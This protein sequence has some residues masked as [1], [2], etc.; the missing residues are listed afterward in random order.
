MNTK[1]K[2]N[3]KGFSLVELIVVMA[4]MAILA[5]TLTP[6][7]TQYIDKARQSNDREIPN[8]VYTAVRLGLLDTTIVGDLDTAWSESAGVEIIAKYYDYDTDKQVCTLK[9]ASS[10]PALPELD[11]LANEVIQVLGK[12]FKFQSNLA[13]GNAPTI[14]VKITNATEG[15]FSVD[16]SYVDGAGKYTMDSKAALGD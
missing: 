9:T 14:V 11:L 10:T 1:V 16:F 7:L 4:I 6:R 5:V 13:K 12:K 2:G 8:G 3:N 15:R